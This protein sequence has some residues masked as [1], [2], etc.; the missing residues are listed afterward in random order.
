[1][2]FMFQI[3]PY[4]IVEAANSQVVRDRDTNHH[5]FLLKKDNSGRHLV[6]V[7]DT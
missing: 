7:E 1:M 2:V 4:P 5:H 3:T 6:E